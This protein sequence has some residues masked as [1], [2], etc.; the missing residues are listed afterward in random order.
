ML[1]LDNSDAHPEGPDAHGRDTPKNNRRFFLG[2]VL[3]CLIIVVFAA[4]IGIYKFAYDTQE[5]VPEPA[6][7]LSSLFASGTW[8]G[9]PD[10]LNPALTL[11]EHLERLR[12]RN[13]K[14]AYQDQYKALRDLVD[15]E[16]FTSNVRRN[17]PLFRDVKAYSFPTF[18]VSGNTANVSGFIEYNNGD[19]SKVDASLVKEGDEWKIATL[20]LVYQ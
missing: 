17:E 3:A 9:F 8:H 10:A 7:D 19:K 18:T 4:A 1:S 2:V 20:T 12:L 13:F 16:E 14:S 11:Q 15:I 6:F 5:Q